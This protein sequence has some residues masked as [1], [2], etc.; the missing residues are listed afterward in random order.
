MIIAE[1]ALS[2]TFIDDD[3]RGMFHNAHE[4]GAL[5]PDA[6]AVVAQYCAPRVDEGYEVEAI[7]R[8]IALRAGLSVERRDDARRSARLCRSRQRQ[9]RRRLGAEYRSSR[10]A[11]LS[12]HLCRRPADRA[13]AG[14]S[15]SRGP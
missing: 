14:Q 9:L 3:S 6:A 8:R 4:Y 7:R 12:R 2:E 13:D 1:G 11:G 5:Y 10:S 15:L